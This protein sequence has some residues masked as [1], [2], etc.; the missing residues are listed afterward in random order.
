MK[1]SFS[2]F[3]R[4]WKE[5]IFWKKIKKILPDNPVILEAGAYDGNDT[6]KMA[7]IW[8]GSI[9]YAFEPVP[10]IFKIL[11]SKTSSFSNI[12]IY[13][14]AL[15]DTTGEQQIFI[16]SGRSNASSSLL[17]PKLHIEIHPDV[18]FN[19]KAL[20][21]TITIN[22]FVRAE[23]IETLDFI[24]LDIQGM[25]IQVLQNSLNSLSKIKAILL[26]VNFIETYHQCFLFEDAK[27]WLEGQGFRL[28]WQG[29]KYEDA[30]NTL[31]VRA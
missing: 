17:A 6:I 15:S 20:A 13:N 7:S 29:P 31:F 30:G 1:Y 8:P 4:K 23:Q 18:H 11:R 24:W 16:S 2:L 26:E 14:T 10:D 21:Q 3:K 28:E 22:D 25:E 27:S 5:Y 9:I 12:K 19:Q